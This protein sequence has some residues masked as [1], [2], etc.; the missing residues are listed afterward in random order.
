MFRAS[1]LILIAA[2][3]A[4]LGLLIQ[5]AQRSEGS[6]QA[7]KV[8]NLAKKIAD[9]VKTKDQTE[10]AI[11]DVVGPPDLASSS[12]PGIQNLLVQELGKL[13]VKINQKASLIVEGK[14]INL[15]EDGDKKVEDLVVRLILYVTNKSATRLYEVS[16][17]VTYKNGGNVDII[18][19]FGMQTDLRQQT[20]ANPD[21]INHQLKKDLEKPPLHLADTKIKTAK[22]SPYAVEVLVQKQGKG[23]FVAALPE[24]NDGK[25]YVALKKGDVYRL[26]LHNG[27]KF[28]AAVT[29]T[30]DGV[31]AFQFFAPEKDKARPTSFLVAPTSARDVKGWPRS[32]E[33]LN[34]FL[35]G[36]YSE[37]AAAEVLK[38]S[39]KL[40]TITLCIFPCWVGKTPPPEYE[41]TRSTNDNGTGIGKEIKEKSN[42]VQRTFGPLVTSITI[43]YNK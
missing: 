13:G 36:S 38:S 34:E 39:A 2:A 19:M 11:N 14:Y 16:E 8:N 26:R 15:T 43:R 4:V 5:P 27:A 25:P 28:E 40:G 42:V 37:S 18:K 29:V 10:V 23:E 35:V 41:G 22:D 20:K 30:I 24:D 6:E 12:G 9:F 21:A 1:R 3:V 17:D 31:D 7:S 32:T 33:K